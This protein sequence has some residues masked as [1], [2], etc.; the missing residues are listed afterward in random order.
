ML[1]RLQWLDE[2]LLP[3]AMSLK[4]NFQFRDY[5]ISKRI[6]FLFLKSNIRIFDYS[7]IDVIRADDRCTINKVTQERALFD[8]LI[9]WHAGSRWQYCSRLSR[10]ALICTKRDVLQDGPQSHSRQLSN[11]HLLFCRPARKV[12]APRTRPRCTANEPC[13]RSQQL[14]STKW[15]TCSLTPSTPAVQNCCRSQVSAPYWSNPP[16]L[17]FDIRALWRLSA[18]APECQKL[19][20]VG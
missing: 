14:Q 4:S 17:M 7:P 20:M 15:R 5:W 9:L 18:R 1:Y 6:V 2:C 8:A 13:Y 10:Y 3:K 19:K 12:C 16:F 11:R